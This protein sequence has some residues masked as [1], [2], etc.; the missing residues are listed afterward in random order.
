MGLLETT[1][2]FSLLYDPEISKFYISLCFADGQMQAHTYD[3]LEYAN[4]DH[5]ISDNDP[6]WNLHDVTE[7]IIGDIDGRSVS[8]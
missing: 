5:T 7:D 8:E 3:K 1:E 2:V 6:A 4:W